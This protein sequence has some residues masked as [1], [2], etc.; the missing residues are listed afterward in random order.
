MNNVY[1]KVFE[2]NN[3][4]FVKIN[5]KL[6]N[7]YLD[8][9]NTPS[10]QDLV[11]SKRKV[12]SLEKELE[13]IKSKIEN[14][15]YVFSM[16]EKDTNMFIGNVELMDYDGESAE[17]AISIT[18]GMQNKHYGQEAIT[19]MINY[20]FNVLGLEQL[21]AVVFSHNERS[22]HCLEKYGFVKYKEVKNVKQL[23]EKEIDDVYLKLNR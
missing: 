1:E 11:N 22:L 14:N 19:I 21:N 23:N 7:E 17:L 12:I 20:A 15:D 3:I 13:W 4:V 10:I 6:I 18:E 16:L 9:V 8:L 5:E 2:S